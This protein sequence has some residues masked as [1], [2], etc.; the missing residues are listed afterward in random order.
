MLNIDLHCHSD[1]SDGM[2]SPAALVARAAANGVDARP[3]V[4]TFSP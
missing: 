2:L 1:A 3:T 4:S